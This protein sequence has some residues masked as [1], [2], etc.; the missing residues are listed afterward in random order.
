M[1]RRTF[2]AVVE[3]KLTGARILDRLLPDLDL[4]VLFSSTGSFLAQPGQA[5]YG[6]AN[7]GLDAIALNRRARGLAAHSIAWGVWRDTGLVKG[8][9]GERNVAEMARQG[10]QSFA[11]ERGAALFQWLCGSAET[12]AIAMPID[13]DLFRRGRGGRDATLYAEVAADAGTDSSGEGALA[14]KLATAGQAERRQL[15][16][17]AVRAAV[18]KVLSINPARID[19]RKAFGSMGLGSLG[20]MELRNRLEAVLGRP[21]SATLAWNHPNVDALVSFLMAPQAKTVT[22]VVETAVAAGSAVSGAI[23]EV[24]ALSDEDALAA[25]R[26]RRPGARR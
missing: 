14:Q 18:G 6:A 5:N 22:Q 21:L 11:P 9:A 4:F 3:P 23:A 26:T 8:E 25:L 24:A 13:W 19:A 1:D 12:L 16:D 17:T 10:I 20:A 15:L 7:A 2:A